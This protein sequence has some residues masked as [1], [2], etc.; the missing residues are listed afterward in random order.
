MHAAVVYR[1][2]KGPLNLELL[3][4]FIYGRNETRENP[5][6]WGGPETFNDIGMGIKYGITSSVTADLTL[7]PDFSQVES[8]AFQVEVNQ[9]YPLFYTEKRPFFM[10]GIDILDFALIPHGNMFTAVHIRRIVDPNWGAKLTG[11]LGKTS[12]GILAA[13]DQ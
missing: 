10:E 5:D 11:T 9:R 8:D 2:L 13:G 3:R 4:S 7:N 1:D 12:L 6:S